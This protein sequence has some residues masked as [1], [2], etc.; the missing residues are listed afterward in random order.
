MF[1]APDTR[2]AVGTQEWQT[3]FR[4]NFNNGSYTD[5][6]IVD[7]NT[8]RLT[9]PFNIYKNVFIPVGVYTWTR[10]QLTYGSPQDR[11]LTVG[12]LER[13]GTYYDGRLNEARVRA[14]YRSN[15]RLA[16]SFS[17]QW[18]RFRLPITNGDFSVVFG[19]FET[20]Y[21]FSRFLSLAT[22]LQMDTANNQTVSTNVRLRWNYRPDSDLFVIYTTGQQFASL[23]ATNPA[24]FYEHRFVIKF[25]YS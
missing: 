21:A 25:T 16:F 15:E 14:S 17:E 2:G 13:F 23:A 7:V 19:A 8:Q 1:H 9:T 11:K 24:Q 20:D 10:H 6:D 22:I 3:T 18:N 12:F 4:A 5:D